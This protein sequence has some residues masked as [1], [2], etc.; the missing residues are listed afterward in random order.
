MGLLRLRAWRRLKQLRFFRVMLQA[1]TFIVPVRPKSCEG[2]SL[3]ILG[4]FLFWSFQGDDD[5][6]E[7]ALKIQARSWATTRLKTKKKEKKKG[8]DCCWVFLSY[9][10][11]CGQLRDDCVF[12]RMSG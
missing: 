2:G 5:H 11:V 12:V 7:A 1:I 3:C 6:G 10:V 4:V 9:C 8:R